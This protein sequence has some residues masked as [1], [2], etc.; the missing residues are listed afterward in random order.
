MTRPGLYLLGPPRIEVGGALLEVD[1]RKAVALLAYLALTRR[2]QTRDTLAGLLWP[3]HGQKRARAALRRTL[4]SL[5]RAR[6]EGWLEVSR[7]MVGLDHEAVWVDVDR[8]RERLAECADHGHPETEV[9]P[10]CLP[11]LSEAVSLYRDDFLAGFGLRDSFAFD[12]WQYFQAEELRRELAGVLEK[13]AWGHGT[14]GEWEAAIASARRRLLLDPLHEPAHRTLMQL[15]ALSGERA[16]ALRQYR[17]CV[18]ILEKELGVAPLEETT[19]FYRAIQEGSDIPPL[20][21]NTA[22]GTGSD[23]MPDIPPGHEAAPVPADTSPA[24][25]SSIANGSPLIGRD[26]GWSAL[27]EA[28]AAAGSALVV[29]EGEAGIGKTRLAEEFLASAAGRGAAVLTARCYGG[30]MDLAYGPFVE[31]LEAA[32]ERPELAAR[33]EQAP[34][35]ALA[36]ASRLLP[37]LAG[38]LPEVTP[39]PPLD[40]PGARSRFFEGVVRTLLAALG[41]ASRD[42][43]PPGILFVDDL[44]WADEA[45][46][47]LLSYLVRRLRGRPLMVLVAWRE[48][49]VPEDHR[50]RAL[51][52]ET[53]EMATVVRLLRLDETAVREMVARS[54][55]SPE[56][57]ERLYRETEGLPLFLIE[58]LTAISRGGL[59]PGGEAWSLP[60]GVQS[61]LR[62][63]L[64]EPGETGGQLLAAA[65]VIGRSFDFDTLRE[66]SGRGEEETVTA[67]EELISHRL[68]REVPTESGEGSPLYDFSHDKLRALAYEETSLARRRLLHRRVAGTLAARAR[69][70]KGSS[71]AQIAHHYRLAG[72]DEE[73]AEQ[74]A[75]AGEH[76]RSLSAHA[77]AL[78]H[79]GT[80]LALGHPDA[81]RLHEAIG[82]IHTLRGEYG[83]AT[84]SYETAAARTEG[85]ALA[86]IERK[87]GDVHARRGEWE[88]AEGHYRTAL[89]DLDGTNHAGERAHLYADLGLLRHHQGRAGE[90]E[91]LAKQALELA[92]DDPRALARAHNTAGMLARSRGDWDTALRH[93]GR[94]LE[95]AETLGDP[96]ARVAALNNLALV[97]GAAGD[98]DRAIHEAEAALAL[99]IASGD[100]HREAALRNNLA[101]LFHAA[102]LPEESMS[103]LKRAVEIFAEVG[104][105]ETMQPGIWKL[106]EW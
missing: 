47:D 89:E 45:S 46:L 8:F 54:G 64:R 13:L 7:D 81:A 60:G 82:D 1:T 97:Y 28:Y 26:S 57:G 88:L 10:A 69:R 51:V 5:A 9:C 49:L 104:E 75:L 71:A 87:L 53:R 55:A 78:S 67:L 85:P 92:A 61:L 99:C 106:T 31:A 59:D 70:E 56:L 84:T 17:E 48:E 96:D 22:P 90:A 80:A 29:L 39:L 12:D 72:R 95:L 52:S 62:G 77:E 79:F 19:L 18:R 23:P 94:S 35:G 36:E 91:E 74:Y 103:Q 3:D 4:S 16:S 65:A 37:A 6:E 98:M 68:I 86:G 42:D 93:L 66:A 58:Y 21:A 2:S 73:A 44:Q 32:A 11:P 14:A 20:P 101:D 30:E 24:I 33:L 76:A 105:E 63:R 15:Y 41:D 34:P 102:G 25:T 38:K 40:T 100:L 50:L 83:A 43:S 27:E